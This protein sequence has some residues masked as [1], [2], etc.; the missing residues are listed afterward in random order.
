M[1]KV[2][3]SAQPIGQRP[4]L[5][6]LLLPSPLPRSNGIWCLAHA[7]ML[8]ADPRAWP[9]VTSLTRYEQVH[10]GHSD[11]RDLL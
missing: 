7:T 6:R 3:A 11:E 1:V 10:G 9:T 2:H 5:L 8:E 4:G